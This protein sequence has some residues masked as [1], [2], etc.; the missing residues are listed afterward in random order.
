MLFSSISAQDRVMV[1]TAVSIL[2]NWGPAASVLTLLVGFFLQ[3]LAVP[4]AR[5]SRLVIHTN[6]R[7]VVTRYCLVICALLVRTKR[8]V[9][10]EGSAEI[11]LVAH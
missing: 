6:R 9:S 2:S 10:R 1:A 11:L 5:Q 4:K 7:R 8:V 3:I